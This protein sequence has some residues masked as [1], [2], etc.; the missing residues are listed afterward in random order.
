MK[1]HYSTLFQPGLLSKTKFDALQSMKMGVVN[2]IFLIYDDL[3]SFFPQDFSTVHPL[4]FNDEKFDEKSEWH[5]NIFNFDKFY[6]NILLVWTSGITARYVEDL[7]EQE[8]GKILVNLMKKF[9]KNENIP[10]PKKVIR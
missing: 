4:F 7:S 6:D 9:L 1:K 8:I 10:I 3:N 2:K 5:L